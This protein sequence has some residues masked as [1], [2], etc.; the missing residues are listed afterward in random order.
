MLISVC[1]IARFN[2]VDICVDVFVLS[3]S[4]VLISVCLV[5]RFYS[6]DICLS[7][8]QVLQC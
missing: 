7:C 4:T 5:V 8:C 3:G 1:L 6:V 2:S